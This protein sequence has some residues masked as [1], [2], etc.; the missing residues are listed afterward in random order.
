[1]KKQWEL[2]N[3]EFEALKESITDVL[4]LWHY[5]FIE[6]ND[7]DGRSTSMSLETFW[8]NLRSEFIINK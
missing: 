1:M 7:G 2:T 6:G 4:D 5:E 3:E 8:T